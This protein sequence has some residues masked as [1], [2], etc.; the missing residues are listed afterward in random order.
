MEGAL[1]ILAVLVAV[2]LLLFY[3]DR[4]KPHQHHNAVAAKAEKA[5][6]TE[7]AEKE[8]Q[9]VCCGLHAVC[10]KK[11]AKPAS[12]KPEYYD[13]EELDVLADRD[14]QTYTEAERDMLRDVVLTLRRED[15]WGWSRSLEMRHIELP[16]DIRDEL[17]MRL[18]D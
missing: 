18:S 6:K 1:V 14:P 16:P 8:Q 13:D 2:G 11:Y 17:L 3:F 10:E 15:A 9:Q 4:R 5:E 7:K 12:D